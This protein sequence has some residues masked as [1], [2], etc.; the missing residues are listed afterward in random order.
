MI[1]A[2]P[3]YTREVQTNL[4]IERVIIRFLCY[5]IGT[6]EN[7]SSQMR[8][9][10]SNSYSQNMCQCPSA[11]NYHKHQVYWYIAG[12]ETIQV[13]N[14]RVAQSEGVRKDI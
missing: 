1:A 8:I 3:V 9:L 4:W 13:R 10:N 11:K 7:F 12:R 6:P 5:I 2:L 14:H